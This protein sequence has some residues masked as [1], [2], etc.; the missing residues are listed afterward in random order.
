M[1]TEGKIF[2]VAE[3]VFQ[4]VMLFGTDGKFE[5]FY[6]AAPVQATMELIINQFWKKILG[7]EQ[8]EVMERYV[9]GE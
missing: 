5:S 8:Q 2:V 1:D 4:G 3:S 7:K 9:P 6:G